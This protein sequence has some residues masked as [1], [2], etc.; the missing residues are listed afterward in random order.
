[1]STLCVLG[2]S[3]YV[4]VGDFLR[5]I[6]KVTWDK[7]FDLYSSKQLTT[8]D[9]ETDDNTGFQC[10]ALHISKDGKY[11]LAVA[12]LKKAFVIELLFGLPF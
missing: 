12:N 7:E 10:S 3:F 11:F 6:M 4:E 8:F 5:S 2:N 1:M 9:C